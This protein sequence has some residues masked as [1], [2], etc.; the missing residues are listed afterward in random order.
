[1]GLVVVL[2][3]WEFRPQQSRQENALI[4]TCWNEGKPKCILNFALLCDVLTRLFNQDATGSAH[5]RGPY[6]SVQ[7]S[8]AKH[9]KCGFKAKRIVFKIKGCHAS[10][11]SW[12]LFEVASALSLSLP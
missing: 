11:V 1:V 12:I 9:A 6:E 10:F 7:R 8:S 4:V 2:K 5:C 3:V